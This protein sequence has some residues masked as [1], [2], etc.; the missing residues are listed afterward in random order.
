MSD[1]DDRAFL[2]RA[3]RLALRGHGGAEPNPMVGCVIVRDGRV[4][5]E[6]FHR[7]CG[8]AHA[9]AMALARAG[10]AAR[11]ATAYVTLEPCNHHGRT[12]PCSEAMRAAGVARVVYASGDPHPKA[13]GG[14]A[15]LA[16]AGVAVERV[17]LPEAD[18]LN[19]PFL[20][21]IATGLPWIVAK[22]AQT[23]DGKIAT[24]SGD[25][26]WLSNPR[27][28]SLVHRERGRV[29]AIVTGIGT[30][31]A[32]DPR[33]TAR[34]RGR[35]RVA[36]RVVVDPDL[37]LPDGRALLDLSPAPLTVATDARRID[38]PR[39][40]ELSGRG[41][42]LLPL[43]ADG[44]LEGVFRELAARHGV[45]TALVESGGGLLG[46]LFRAGLVDECLVFIAP[47]LAGDTNAPGPVRGLAAERVA[48]L[49]RFR[50]LE[51]RRRGDD[52]LLRYRA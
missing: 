5:A 1:A 24:A 13:Q 47:L 20:K 18:E 33:L 6:G 36:R 15:R 8:E 35:R 40:R 21:R 16:A 34:G 52:V 31:L 50:L 23:L 37:A 14:A 51:S 7:R 28:R 45:A 26:R 4:I 27:S 32:D 30:V 17:P 3:V 11:G 48:D 9:E 19:R 49:R 43:S 29:D 41:V 2:R 46:Q 12:P 42:E 38:S 22:W 39:G 44:G 10:D 25:S